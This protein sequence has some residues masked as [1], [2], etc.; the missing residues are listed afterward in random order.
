MEKL[1]QVV[2]YSYL[3]ETIKNSPNSQIKIWQRK[4]L[5]KVKCKMI[6]IF[7]PRTEFKKILFQNC[8]IPGLS[9]CV[10]QPGVYALCNN[11]FW[12][13]YKIHIYILAGSDGQRNTEGNVI[14]TYNF[15][16]R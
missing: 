7:A 14:S 8:L 2:Y 13:R 4:N 3:F 11:Y 5:T 15:T 10:F 9:L 12:T 1:A 16:E 6:L